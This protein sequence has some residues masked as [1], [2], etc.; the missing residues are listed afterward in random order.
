LVIT[1]SYTASLASIL[2]QE[3]EAKGTYQDI[4]EALRKNAQICVP[5]TVFETF[6]KMYP[7]GI[8]AWR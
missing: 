2:V 3:P 6:K 1:A 7:N 4:N 8:S 5:D